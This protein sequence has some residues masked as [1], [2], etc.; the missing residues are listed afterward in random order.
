MNLFTDASR[1]LLSRIESTVLR[2]PGHANLSPANPLF[3]SATDQ[4]PGLRL[5]ATLIVAHRVGATAAIFS[6]VEGLGQ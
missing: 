3:R 2:G 5:T 1:C 4:E 6:L